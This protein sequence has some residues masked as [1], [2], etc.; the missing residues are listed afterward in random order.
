MFT[1]YFQIKLFKVKTKEPLDD[2]EAKFCEKMK[3][4]IECIYNQ[5]SKL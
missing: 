2:V 3:K 1:Q 5:T 4:R